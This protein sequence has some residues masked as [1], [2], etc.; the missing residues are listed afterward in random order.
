MKLATY[1]KIKAAVIQAGFAEELAWS[2]NVKAPESAIKFAQEYLW[3]VL[4]SGMKF[5]IARQ[6][7]GRVLSALHNNVRIYPPDANIFGHKNKCKAIQGTWDRKDELFA[8]FVRVKDDPDKVM[9]FVISLPYTKGKIIRYHFLKN[10]GIDVAKPDRHLARIADKYK[11]TPKDICEKL[12]AE[13]GDRIA[14]CDLVL[15]RACEQGFGYVIVEADKQQ[16]EDHG[17][18]S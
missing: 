6:I 11:T 7:E 14:T 3:C 13:S 18:N 8:E 9:N 16:E 17:S 1:E 15:W 12:A 10:L 2:E 4:C 5:A